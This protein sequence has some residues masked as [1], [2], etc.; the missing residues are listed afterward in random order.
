MIKLHC[1]FPAP[2]SFR[3]DVQET[4]SLNLANN[5]DPFLCNKIE[6]YNPKPKISLER[7]TPALWRFPGYFSGDTVSSV[8]PL[9]RQYTLGSAIS[10]THARANVI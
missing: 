2:I 8:A 10:A 3:E 7:T 6:H 5:S 1:V 4:P 9:K